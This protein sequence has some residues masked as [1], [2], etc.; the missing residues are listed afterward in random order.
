VNAKGTPFDG[1]S[2]KTTNRDM[3]C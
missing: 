2:S 1:V 3:M